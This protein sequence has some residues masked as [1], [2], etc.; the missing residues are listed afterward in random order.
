MLKYT[1]IGAGLFAVAFTAQANISSDEE[2]FCEELGDMARV[3]ALAR[4][5]GLSQELLYRSVE[6]D[7]EKMRNLML[8]SVDLVYNKHE[9]KS[10]RE[11]GGLIERQC[12]R[13][14]AN[15]GE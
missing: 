7:N 13:G 9:D 15:K 1:A 4:E 8:K 10:P 2:E 6:E 12:V 5:Q 14:Y 3:T 11:V